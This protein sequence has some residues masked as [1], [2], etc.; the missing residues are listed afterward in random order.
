MTCP[1][2][3]ISNGL[4][5]LEILPS[6]L[7]SWEFILMLGEIIQLYWEAEILWKTIWENL[8]K[9]FPFIIFLFS[10]YHMDHL[11][12]IMSSYNKNNGWAHLIHFPYAP[13]S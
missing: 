5:L 13:N 2:K 11:K 9:Q 4:L 7:E 6:N 3:E 12:N 1:E 8:I 10:K